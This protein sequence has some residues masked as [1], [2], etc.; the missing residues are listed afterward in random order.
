VSGPNEYAHDY[1]YPPVV[2]ALLA[3]FKMLGLRLQVVG[4]DNVPRR[5]PAVMASNHIS[6]LDFIFVG[7]GARRSRRYVR[8]MAKE[9]I[10]ANRVAGPL[11][12]GMHHI[13]VDREAGL[14]SYRD[15]L[16]ALKTGEVVGVFPEATISR[17]FEPKEFKSGA[18]RLAKSSKTP[19]IPVAVWGS[20]RLWTYDER[21]SLWQRGVP[22]SIYVGEPIDVSFTGDAANRELRRR[23]TDLVHRAQDEYPTDGK[24]QWWQPARLGG[25]APA[26]PPEESPSADLS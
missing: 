23:V 10:F 18:E 6:H 1:V 25:T 14:Q 15:A 11:M 5:G 20:H 21:A 7:L 22:I 8:F 17:S 16:G 9:S 2:T 13:S 24:G 12:R 3:T 4:A 26:A 19:L